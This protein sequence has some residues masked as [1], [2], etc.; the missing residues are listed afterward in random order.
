MIRG[1]MWWGRS[2]G[3][4]DGDS[5]TLGVVEAIHGVQLQ[6]HVEAVGEQQHHE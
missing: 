1:G 2:L 3:L 6:D 5:R 4:R